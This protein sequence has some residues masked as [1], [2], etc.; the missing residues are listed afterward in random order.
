MDLIINQEVRP[1]LKVPEEGVL[2]FIE[3]LYDRE[4][5]NSWYTGNAMEYEMSTYLNKVRILKYRISD[6]GNQE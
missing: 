3:F 2:A 4:S 1:R 5:G 6:N